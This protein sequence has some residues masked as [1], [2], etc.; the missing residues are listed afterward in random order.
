[1]FTESSDRR[2]ESKDSVPE[3]TEPTTDQQDDDNDIEAR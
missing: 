3:L 2:K 1:M